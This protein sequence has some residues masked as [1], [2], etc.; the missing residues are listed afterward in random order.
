[1]SFKKIYHVYHEMSHFGRNVALHFCHRHFQIWIQFLIEMQYSIVT[2]CH[3]CYVVILHDRCYWTE[4]HDLIN[5]KG[6]IESFDWLSGIF[7]TT[8]LG[9][10]GYALPGIVTQA[11]RAASLVL[12]GAVF[13]ARLPLDNEQSMSLRRIFILWKNAPL[14]RISSRVF[15]SALGQYLWRPNRYCLSLN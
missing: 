12:R 6:K 9:M 11:T 8:F 1:M 14:F 2:W 10:V 15:H 7:V 5:G 13:R 4:I 3:V